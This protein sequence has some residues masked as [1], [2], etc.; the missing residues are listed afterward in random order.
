MQLVH[1]YLCDSRGQT[2]QNS[3]TGD[4]R[5]NATHGSTTNVNQQR[6]QNVEGGDAPRSDS[7]RP[8]DLD[9]RIEDLRIDDLRDEPVRNDP[10]VNRDQTTEGRSA[11]NNQESDESSRVNKYI[12]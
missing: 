12:L 1:Y 9:L 5:G 3:G 10:T 8:G 11:E 2:Q 7:G 6:T 4:Q